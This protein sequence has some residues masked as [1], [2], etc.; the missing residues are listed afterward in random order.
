MVVQKSEFQKW[1]KCFKGVE[2]IFFVAS[3][4]CYDEINEETKVNCM[5]ESLEMFDVMINNEHLPNKGIILFLN[6]RDLFSKKL[7]LKETPIT[8]C[9]AFND[10]EGDVWSYEETTKYIRMKYKSMVA[11][12][13]FSLDN[14]IQMHLTCAMEEENVKKVFE[15]V[16]LHG[17]ESTLNSAGLY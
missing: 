12:S 10:F 14:P 4:S 7:H 3:L 2:Y 11:A 15:S 6:K 13:T 1:I 5:V 9:P 8:V 17:I 16:K